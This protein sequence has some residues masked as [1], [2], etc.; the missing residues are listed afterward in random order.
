MRFISSDV[1]C[2]IHSSRYGYQSATQLEVAWSALVR[3]KSGTDL[4]MIVTW[5]VASVTNLIIYADTLVGVNIEVRP[6]PGGECGHTRTK[7]NSLKDVPMDA[8]RR[9]RGMC[10]TQWK[11][12]DIENKDDEVTRAYHGRKQFGCYRKKLPSRRKILI[13]FY[14][15]KNVMMDTLERQSRMHLARSPV[16]QRGTAL[17]LPRRPSTDCCP[18]THCGWQ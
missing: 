10:C 17:W 4:R 6:D 13:V 5:D 11:V 18:Q 8:L 2:N 7:Y 12:V 9:G 14:R 1:D 15:L 16:L 3:G